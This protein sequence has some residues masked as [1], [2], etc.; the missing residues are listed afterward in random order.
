MKLPSQD[1]VLRS[2]VDPAFLRL[3]AGLKKPPLDSFDAIHA[4]S[5]VQSRSLTGRDI[6]AIIKRKLDKPLGTKWLMKAQVATL[7]GRAIAAATAAR[8]TLLDPPPHM[9]THTHT[10]P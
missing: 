5:G 9:H 1:D 3:A 4:L 7:R 8:N 6:D 10:C 2:A